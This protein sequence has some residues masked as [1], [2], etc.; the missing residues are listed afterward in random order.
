VVLRNDW[1]ALALWVVVFPV[2]FSPV[3]TTSDA[4]WVI[5]PFVLAANICGFML[6]KRVGLGAFVVAMFVD[7]LF[8][9]FPLTVHASAWY[10]GYGYA[11]LAIV[12]AIALYGFKTSLGGRPFVADVGL[13]DA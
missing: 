7:R 10:A 9:D 2:V 8:H 4:P 12:A 1:G 3:I 5:A 13:D 6:L 11:A